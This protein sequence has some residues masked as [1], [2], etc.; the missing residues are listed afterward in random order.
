MHMKDGNGTC[1]VVIPGLLIRLPKNGTRRLVEPDGK[2]IDLPNDGT[3]RLVES[4]GPVIELGK[5]VTASQAARITGVS[6]RTVQAACDQGRL[7]EGEDWHKIYGRGARGEYRIRRE[8][9]GKLRGE[10][11]NG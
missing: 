11:A 9:L 2:I 1:T 6:V 4:A 10:M 5:M 7:T 3:A 8:A